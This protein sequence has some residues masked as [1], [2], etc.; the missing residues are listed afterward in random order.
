MAHNS[1]FAILLR[2][3]WWISIALAALVTLVSTALL[4]KDIA[5]FRRHPRPALLGNGRGGRRAPA[6]GARPR[7]GGAGPGD[8]RPAK[9]AGVRR[10]ARSRLAGGGLHRDP[11]VRQGRRRLRAGT[12]RPRHRGQRQALEGRR[13][14]HGAAA[15]PAG[16]R[17]SESTRLNSSHL[18]ITYAVLCLY[19]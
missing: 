8:R 12:R 15:R 9:R 4:P 7:K 13:A 18:V 11:P 16:R 3:R 14:R 6:A 17:R 5:A 2:S 19:R 1:L 10:S